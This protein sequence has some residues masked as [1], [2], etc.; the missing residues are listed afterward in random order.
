MKYF[1]VQVRT[2]KE[3]AYIARVN[4]RL[5]FRSE[6]QRFFFPKR[7]LTIRRLGKK[8]DEI[9]PVFP[10]YLFLETDE[11]DPELFGIMRST[12]DFGR[13]LKNNK[14]ITPIE[15]R[16]LALLQHF[17][18]FGQIADTSVV[19]FNENDRICVKSG[20]LQGLEGFVVKVDKRKQRAKIS[21]DFANENFVID[22]AFNILEEKGDDEL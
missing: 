21:L 14:D 2:L 16:D 22:L 5:Q 18:R 9:R 1:A 19:T 20:T 6:K 15:G 17:L 8:S 11:I 4:D 13:F 3:D 12:K 7:K 10:G